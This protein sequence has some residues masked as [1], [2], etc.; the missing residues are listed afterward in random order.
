M[1]SN[2][3]GGKRGLA[4]ALALAMLTAACSRVEL[5]TSASDEATPSTLS[6]VAQDDATTAPTTEPESTEAPTTEAASTTEAT[7]TT[8]EPTTTTT[9]AVDEMPLPTDAAGVA[10]ELSMVELAVRDS[11]IS[12]SEIGPYGRRQQQMYRLISANPEWAPQVIAAV[13]PAIRPAV[14][15]NWAAREDLSALV[16][17]Y[18]LSTTLPAWRIREPLPVAELVGYYEESA[19][20]SG[21]DWTY[22]AAINLV[23]T[24]MGRIEG[25]STAGATGPMQFLPTTWNECC[26]GDPTVDRDAIIGAGVYLRQRGGPA[27]MQSA[28]FGY[29]NSQRYVD[30]VSAYA[31]VMVDDPLAY[32]GYHAWEVYFL[33][34]AGLIRMPAGYE[35][36]E[37]VDASTWLAENPDA[38]VGSAD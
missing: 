8:A 16:R 5:E 4:L 11:T 31:A 38:L 28:L 1:R 32:R 9:V 7:T 10:D 25:L 13:D 14:E 30:A 18:T 35:E 37:A 6:S 24:R 15:L 27:D 26:Q 19:A 34:A 20:N 2:R 3:N 36:A 33:S 23:E 17:N 29:N 12:D 22:V 21:I